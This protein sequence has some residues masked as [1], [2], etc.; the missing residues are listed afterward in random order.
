M[1]TLVKTFLFLVSLA[2]LT[3]C[4][5]GNTISDDAAKVS[6]RAAEIT[7]FDLPAGYRP[8][9]SASLNGY[10]VASFKPEEKHS[11]LYLLQSEEQADGEKLTRMLEELAP[12]AS[13]AQAR[14][15]V[16]E[17]R[18]VQVRGQ[19]ATLVISDATN[20]EG[21]A[22]R[23]AMVIF[24]GKRGPALAMLSEPIENWDQAKVETFLAS[25]H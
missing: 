21:Q 3:A 17:N 11:H 8:E 23:Q 25:M 15:T 12:G 5:L 13:N 24:Q 10:S 1:N 4:G 19:D 22:Y 18:A 14:T 2:G 9:F 6:A 7:E 16:V 20:S